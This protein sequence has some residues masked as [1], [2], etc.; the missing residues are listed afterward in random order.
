[1]SNK[2]TVSCYYWNVPALREWMA[3][4]RFVTVETT[5]TDASSKPDGHSVS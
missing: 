1:M 3:T 2:L 4:P 5:A